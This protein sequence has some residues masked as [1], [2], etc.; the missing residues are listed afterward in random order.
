MSIYVT[1]HLLSHLY[2]HPITL[3]YF[4]SLQTFYFSFKDQK[5][6]HQPPQVPQQQSQ[7]SQQPLPKEWMSPPPPYTA[8]PIRVLGQSNKR[9]HTLPI[10]GP[11]T[12]KP[13]GEENFNPMDFFNQLMWLSD[14]QRSL[15]VMLSDWPYLQW[16]AIVVT[17]GF[18]NTTIQD[19]V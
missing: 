13:K 4:E 1:F 7:Q 11:P 12:K 3:K 17:L 2:N 16:H 14:I 9:P 5:P 18:T 8:Q 15:V 10:N 19:I 6:P